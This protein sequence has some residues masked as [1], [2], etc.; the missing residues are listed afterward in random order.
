MTAA[1]DPTTHLPA[2]LIERIRARAAAV[3]QSGSFSHEDLADLASAGY[4]RILVPADRGG[5]GLTL[6]Q[7]SI[8]QQ[9]L[10][11]ASPSTALAVNMHLVWTAVARQLAA[12]S[13]DALAFVLDG[14][15]RGEIFAFGI[16]E[17]GNDRV[18][19]DSR[20][21]AR[22]LP[23]GGYSF[24]GT[25]IFTSLA[26]VWT[27]LGLHGRDD[28]N[29]DAPALVFAFVGRGPA[30]ETRD[31]WDV[32]GMRG[33]QSRTTVL[34]GAEAAADRVVRRVLDGPDPLQVAIF[35]AFEL[36][37]ASVYTGLA[38]RAL[39]LAVDAARARPGR[40]GASARSEDPLV[41]ARI[42][43]MAIAYDAL[44][45]ALATLTADVEAGADHGAA[46]FRL[47]AGMKDRAAST[48]LR[49]VE[50]ALLVAGGGAYRRGH[51]LERISRD[52]RAGAFHP[53]SPDAARE[54]AAASWID[55]C[56]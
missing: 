27:S 22:P 29:P 2:E 12:Q 21:A 41:R 52:V 44:P 43:D 45:L 28:S 7:A 31:D 32:Q 26:P 48:A 38:R 13:D 56:S 23:G 1:F 34:T 20:T 33:T 4:L 24:T 36:L 18:L 47:L 17:P 35:A 37:V 5:A 50:D 14:A 54:T 25:K 46:T 39:E 51:E 11:T 19:F 30:I 9:R 53:S 8:L 10:A 49:V 6:P 3:D 55:V 15:A 40:A 16:S 42:G